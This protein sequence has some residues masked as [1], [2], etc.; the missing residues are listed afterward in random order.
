[1]NNKE[2]KFIDLPNDMIAYIFSFVL[3]EK[4][5]TIRS[6]SIENNVRWLC[7]KKD[8]FIKSYNNN[9]NS[10]VFA[11]YVVVFLSTLSLVHPKI[12]F[13]MK[14]QCVFVAKEEWYFK[15]SFFCHLKKK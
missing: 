12:R 6:Y 10:F 14:S 8:R 2:L 11:R 1:M 9:N 5:Q 13:I 15:Q 3:I 4:V 7:D